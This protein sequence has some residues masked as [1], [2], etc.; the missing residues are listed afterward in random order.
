VER[1]QLHAGDTV[2]NYRLV[3]VDG[4][5]RAQF[6]DLD[7]DSMGPAVSPGQS[8]GLEAESPRGDFTHYKFTVEKTDASSQSVTIRGEATQ[9]SQ[10]ASGPAPKRP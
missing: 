4:E 9:S 5:G 6:W 8:F 10:P 3:G 1:A 2:H 7:H